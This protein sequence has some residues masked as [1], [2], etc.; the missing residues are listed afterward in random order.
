QERDHALEVAA[1]EFGAVRHRACIEQSLEVDV[2]VRGVWRVRTDEEG[3][4]IVGDPVAE[5]VDARIKRIE[6]Y[7]AANAGIGAAAVEYRQ[8]R[9]KPAAISDDHDRHV[10]EGE[11]L[12]RIAV[13]PSQL[14]GGF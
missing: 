3:R 12:A 10:G 11:G 4:S 6:K 14:D 1:A 5:R 8:G 13:E 7:K 2:V 9:A